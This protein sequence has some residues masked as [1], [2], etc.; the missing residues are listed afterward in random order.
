MR[1]RRWW[2]AWERAC[3]AGAF[4]L[5]AHAPQRVDGWER[6]VALGILAH[7]LVVEAALAEPLA[8]PAAFPAARTRRAASSGGDHLTPP[9]AG[10]D[11]VGSARPLIAVGARR[12]R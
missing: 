8:R 6:Q 1:V 10:S 7:A 12:A 3:V 5:P 11:D 2:G 9:A 4:A